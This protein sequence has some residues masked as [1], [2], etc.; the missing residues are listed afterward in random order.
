[1]KPKSDLL[2]FGLYVAPGTRAADASYFQLARRDEAEARLD[3]LS[4]LRCAQQ[5]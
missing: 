4:R 2:F 1:M 5:P 3:D